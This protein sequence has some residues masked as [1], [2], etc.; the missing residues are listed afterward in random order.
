MSEIQVGQINSTDGST[1]ITV[2]T[3]NTTLS[4][5]LAMGANNISFSNGNGIDFSA[6]EG[7]GADS[8]V[9]DDYEQG[10]FIPSITTTATVGAYT[11]QQ[12]QYTK[13]GNVCHWGIDLDVPITGTASNGNFSI[14]LPFTSDNVLQTQAVISTI[15][16][17]NATGSST[18]PKFQFRVGSGSSSMFIADFEGT[19]NQADEIGTG[20]AFQIR[21]VGWFF[22]A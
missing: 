20:S 1:A 7:S 17:R 5:S 16:V 9:L 15:I 19:A 11:R 22:T 21:C 2:S 8:S 14:N 12:G 4:G 3:G 13:I 18:S 6:S 10:T